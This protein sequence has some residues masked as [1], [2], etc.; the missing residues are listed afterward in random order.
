VVHLPFKLSHRR[1]VHLS[2]LYPDPATFIC[3]TQQTFLQ[4]PNIHASF[5][6]S[7]N[8]KAAAVNCSAPFCEME[9]M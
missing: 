5:P 3:T 6:S 9:S 4:I 7:S 2:F 1:Q 8:Q